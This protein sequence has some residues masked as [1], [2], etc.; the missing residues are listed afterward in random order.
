MSNIITPRNFIRE[1]LYK[2]IN[3][4]VS[5]YFYNTYNKAQYPYAIVDI[6]ELENE[7]L[8]QYSLDVSVYDKKEDTTDIE[9]ICDDLKK[10]FHQKREVKENYAYAIWFSNCL[11]DKEEDRT[12]KKRILSFEIHLFKYE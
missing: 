9:T 4:V 7:V 10:L 11:T 8:T 3:S 6:K 5:N 1:E 12:I 2:E